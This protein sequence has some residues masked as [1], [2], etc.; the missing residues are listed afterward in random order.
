MALSSLGTSPKRTRSKLQDQLDELLEKRL[1]L[2]TIMV[3]AADQHAAAV[4]KADEEYKRTVSGVEKRLDEV[5]EELGAFLQRNQYQLIR[6]LG[7]T[8]KHPRA[9][10]K[11]VL[12]GPQL[13][14]PKGDKAIIDYLEVT[15]GGDAYL[16]YTPKLDRRALQQAP[17]ALIRKL[18]PFGVWKGKHRRISVKSIKAENP[19]V[20]SH[21]RFN[22]RKVQ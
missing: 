15:P 6:R 19:K 9:E 22:E 3:D 16:S 2:V 14:I 20:L 11:F 17:K 4:K 8:I 12:E 7:R 21:K 1:P 10:V 13:E 18:Y 5:D